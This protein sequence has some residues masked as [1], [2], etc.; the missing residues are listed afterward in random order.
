MAGKL[1]VLAGCA[2]V[3]AA[4]SAQ[5]E[6]GW[7]FA[8]TPYFFLPTMDGVA[9]VGPFEQ[10]INSRPS[11][12]LKKLDWGVM[13]NVEWG[14]GN[15]ALLADGAYMN[16]N[17]VDT[18]RARVVGYQG[19]YAV[20]GLVR[21]APR[22]EAY[23]GLRVNTLGASVSYT[24]LFGKPRSGKVRQVWYD[25]M[26]GVRV[27]IPLSEATTLGFM[28]EVGGFGVGSDISWSA[29]PTLS[30][31][32]NDIISAQLGYRFGYFEYHNDTDLGL[33][34]YEVMAHG[35]SIGFKFKF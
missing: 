32:L 11:A 23:S 7:Y 3:V 16:L 18:G 20:M 1:K 5:A 26:V 35:P 33:F 24:G 17:L 27:T 29:W 9:G 22:L 21:V 19:T 4:A 15:V 14:N 28:G 12:L 8:A 34:T 6:D 13:G 31:G 10:G 30:L 25:P 2:A